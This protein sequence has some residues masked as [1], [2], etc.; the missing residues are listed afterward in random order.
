LV[1]AVPIATLAKLLGIGLIVGA[2]RRRRKD[3]LRW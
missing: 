1:L 3:R 2:A